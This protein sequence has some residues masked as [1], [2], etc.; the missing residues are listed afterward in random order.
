M[1]MALLALLALIVGVSQVQAAA[2]PAEGTASEA[3]SV[4]DTIADGSE[5]LI[6]SEPAL[7]LHWSPARGF[8]YGRNCCKRGTAGRAARVS[9]Q[10]FAGIDAAAGR[11]VYVRNRF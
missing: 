2:R 3:E 11:P 6:A 8:H 10:R 7:S 1:K 5:I 4:I 9:S